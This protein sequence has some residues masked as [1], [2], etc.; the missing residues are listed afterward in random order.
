MLRFPQSERGFQ[1]ALPD[2]A[3]WADKIENDIY[4]QRPAHIHLQFYMFTQSHAFTRYR[5][6]GRIDI[7]NCTVWH[8]SQCFGPS[9]N[10]LCSYLPVDSRPSLN[11]LDVAPVRHKTAGHCSIHPK[12]IRGQCASSIFVLTRCCPVDRTRYRLTQSNRG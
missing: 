7:H 8:T 3:P 11:F 6:N 9:P 12:F 2:V 1:A 10:W 4:A 5:E